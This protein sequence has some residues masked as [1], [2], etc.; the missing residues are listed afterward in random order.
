MRTLRGKL[1]RVLLV[2]A[3]AAAGCGGGAGDRPELVDVEGVVT[4]DGTPLPEASVVFIPE[5]GPPSYG[6]TDE[7]GEYSLSH[8]DD[9]DGAMIGKHKVRIFTFREAEEDEEGNRTERVPERV[10]E[11]YNTRTELTA[12]IGPDS[13]EPV[14]FDLKSDGKVVQPVEPSDE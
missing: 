6:L 13:D 4:L 12:E 8:S 10:P 14:N 1:D 7:N 2:C 3:V 9:A 5:N 11:K